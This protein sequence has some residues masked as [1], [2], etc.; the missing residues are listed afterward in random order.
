MSYFSPK[1][2]NYH[3]LKQKYGKVNLCHYCGK[4]LLG[5]HPYGCAPHPIIFSLE[6]V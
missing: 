2:Y 4:T 5:L 6:R 1:E 3:H